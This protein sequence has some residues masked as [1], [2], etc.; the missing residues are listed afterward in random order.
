MKTAY[1]KYFV[2]CFFSFSH[3]IVLNFKVISKPI[4]VTLE[5]VFKV[6]ELIIQNGTGSPLKPY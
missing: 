6:L 5:Q 4:G 2:K 3:K 1:S